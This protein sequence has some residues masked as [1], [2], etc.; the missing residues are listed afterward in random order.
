MGG[1]T[2]TRGGVLIA[3]VGLPKQP[4]SLIRFQKT[5]NVMTAETLM[6][7]RTVM[8][9]PGLAKKTVNCRKYR[10]L[11]GLFRDLDPAG[12]YLDRLCADL[13]GCTQFRRTGA[14]SR[15]TLPGL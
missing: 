11:Q 12:I 3:P 15:K 13:H 6:S 2:Q 8:L 5:D 9:Q 1:T 4:Q 10:R 14:S 7:V